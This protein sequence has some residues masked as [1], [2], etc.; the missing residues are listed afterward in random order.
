MDKPE[1]EDGKIARFFPQHGIGFIQAPTDNPGVHVMFR[2]SVIERGQQINSGGRVK[3]RRVL[4]VKNGK[5][6]AP[7]VIVVAP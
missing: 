1:L 6:Y 4:N 3:F 5:W 7:Y 2:S